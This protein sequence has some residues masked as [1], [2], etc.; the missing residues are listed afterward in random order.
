MMICKTCG[1]DMAKGVRGECEPWCRPF[2]ALEDRIGALEQCQPVT[3]TATFE[4]GG[5]LTDLRAELRRDLGRTN[6]R[7]DRHDRG[8]RDAERRIAEVEKRT[9]PQRWGTKE[10]AWAWVL[11]RL[12]K[13][14]E[15]GTP[16]PAAAELIK[17]IDALEQ[18]R[19]KTSC[20][21]EWGATIM[22]IDKLEDWSHGADERLDTH[23]HIEATRT[24]HHPAG[25]SACECCPPGTEAATRTRAS[26]FCE[27]KHTWPRRAPHPTDKCTECGIAAE[28]SR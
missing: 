1:G 7:V 10:S 14:E 23:K 6:V 15:D 3:V 21:A 9:D 27:G 26:T 19:P 25:P 24:C 13:L 20:P 28:A 11:E 2:K 17:R 4:D 8:L 18:R 16:W 12:D 5:T 22:R